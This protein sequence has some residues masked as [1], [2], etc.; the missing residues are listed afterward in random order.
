MVISAAETNS[1]FNEAIPYFLMVREITKD[2]V[3]DNALVYAYARTDKLVDLEVI[4]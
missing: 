4:T 3:L 1:F 2:A